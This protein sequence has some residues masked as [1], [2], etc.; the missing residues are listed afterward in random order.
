MPHQPPGSEARESPARGLGA[1]AVIAS[2]YRLDRL[3]ARGGM[4]SVWVAW[5]QV[6]ERP[7]AVKFMHPQVAASATLRERFNREAKAAARLRSPYVVQIFDHGVEDDTPYIVMELLEGE[8]LQ[9]RLKRQ[10]RL[11]LGEATPIFMQAAKA[12][13]VAHRA[14]IVHRDLKPQNIFLA[15][16]DDGDE[17]VRILDFGIAKTLEAAGG[18][19]ATKTGDVFGTPYYM[20]PEQ[21]RGF[22]SIDQRSDLWSLAVIMYRSLTGKRAFDGESAGDII[23]KICT[24]VVPPPSGRALGLPRAVDAFFERALARNPDERFQSAQE[25][26]EAFLAVAVSELPSDVLTTVPRPSTWSSPGLSV[27]QPESAPAA[28]L[29]TV[30]GVSD[31]DPEA[32]PAEGRRSGPGPAGMAIADDGTYEGPTRERPLPAVDRDESGSPDS[33]PLSESSSWPAGLA[34]A[35]AKPPPRAPASDAADRPEATGGT[36]GSVA[37]DETASFPKRRSAVLAFVAAAAAV[38][39]VGVT[40]FF[41]GR[42]KATSPAPAAPATTATAAAAEPVREAVPPPPRSRRPNETAPAPGSASAASPATPSTARV[43]PAAARATAAVK[44]AAARQTASPA[45]P[46]P[47]ASAPPAAK[48]APKPTSGS[49]WGY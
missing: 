33:G 28:T 17:A 21:A 26:A 36:L 20:S 38:V 32:G 5:D 2:K 49:P 3:L 1:G 7:V 30:T 37:R 18:S 14:G 23:V 4:G 10:G 25:M 48:P 46:K 6:L 42:P 8:E 34:A 9:D 44:A 40:G 11:S 15:R 47:V 43:P 45:P 22:K 27:P 24:E 31:A 35:G 19:D 41:L 12:L 13:Q 29:V 16:S 39:V